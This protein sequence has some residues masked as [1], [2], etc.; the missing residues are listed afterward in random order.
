MLRQTEVTSRHD[1]IDQIS[2]KTDSEHP[3]KKY[4]QQKKDKKEYHDK[5]A[6]SCELH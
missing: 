1:G 5:T 4:I 3:K 2:E 6:H